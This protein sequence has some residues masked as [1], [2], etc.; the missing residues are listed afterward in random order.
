MGHGFNAVK[1]GIDAVHSTPL[2]FAAYIKTE[3]TRWAKVIRN[4]NIVVE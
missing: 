2:E 3:V 1:V 4:A